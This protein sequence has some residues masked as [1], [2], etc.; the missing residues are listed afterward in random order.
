MS[1]FRNFAFTVNNYTEDDISVLLD[2]VNTDAKYIVFGR[3]VGK[4]G[5][6]HLQGTVVWKNQKSLMAAKRALMLGD[7]PH[8]EVCMDLF[9]SI[10]YCKK[11]GKFDEEGEA[12]VPQKERGRKGKEAAAKRWKTAYEATKS[13][14]YSAV[15]PQ[16]MITQCRNLEFLEDKARRSL[17]LRETPHKNLWLYGPTRTGKSREARKWFG[18]KAYL[19]EP[20]TKWW[21]NYKDEPYVIVEELSPEHKYMADRY[22]RWADRYV[23]PAEKKG[24][25]ITIRPR[26]M[27]VT[28]NYKPSDIWTNA[29]DLEPLLERFTLIEFGS[30]TLPMLQPF[31][32]NEL[33]EPNTDV[34]IDMSD[35]VSHVSGTPEKRR[36]VESDDESSGSQCEVTWGNG[37]DIED[38]DGIWFDA[39]DE[40]SEGES[41]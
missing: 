34:V 19:K 5:T 3:E 29:A 21:D 25:S 15:E 38:E 7:R 8:I 35:D 31:V 17:P 22:K 37:E 40:M 26:M 9:G 14:D 20:G 1:K 23:F 2:L 41:I 27:I 32:L 16:I 4:E 39:D 13:G 11:D 30:D 24:G 28:S 36:R 10:D 18:P 6:P 33:D 12:P